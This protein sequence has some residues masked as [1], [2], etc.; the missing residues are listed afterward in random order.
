MLLTETKPVTASTRKDDGDET[1][2]GQPKFVSDGLKKDDVDADVIK[3][4][5][6]GR[7]KLEAK[8]AMASRRK[9]DVESESRTSKQ[10]LEVTAST[11]TTSISNKRGKQKLE[12]LSSNIDRPL[13]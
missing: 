12:V 5:P 3:Q 7:Q 10:N 13:G 2:S 6:S 9:D 1:R 11:R 8:P 4:A